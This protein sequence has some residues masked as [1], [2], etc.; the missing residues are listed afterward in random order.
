[1]DI[2]VNE[3]SCKAGFLD[4]R[5]IETITQPRSAAMDEFLL[6]VGRATITVGGEAVPVENGMLVYVRAGETYTMSDGCR[7]YYLRLK[8]KE[9]AIS[10]KLDAWPR[11]LRLH[12]PKRLAE[13]IEKVAVADENGS[14]K[15]MIAHVLDIS[16]CLKDE[17]VDA[18]NEKG[19]LTEKTLQA[20]RNG[21][22]YMDEH[23]REKCSLNE[24]AAHVG[25]SPIYFHDT[26]ERVMGQSPC[27]YITALR[28]G[29]AK[30]LLAFTDM[31]P[32]DIAKESGYGSQ[33]Y[34]NYAFKKALGLTPLSY[35][36]EV[37]CRYFD[38]IC[39]VER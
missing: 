28:L 34:F 35:R 14:F 32:A 20:V 15:D 19:K 25:R 17:I 7:A 38:E 29:E 2:K 9:P 21:A 30:R 16:A 13:L 1:M 3:F 18:Q 23:F 6:F 8:E 26:F 5:Y 27:E 36:R 24:V 39:E 22:A 33:S 37:R 31:D 12:D 11:Q 4:G 10:A